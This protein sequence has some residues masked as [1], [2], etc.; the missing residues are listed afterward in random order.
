MES[1]AEGMEI[2][3]EDKEQISSPSTLPLN[4][5][6]FLGIFSFALLIR[7]IY[8][9][10]IKGDPTFNVPLLDELYHHYWAREIAFGDW[11]GR[12]PFFRAP[13][14]PYFLAILYKIFDVNP[15]SAKF[16]QIFLGSLN[17]VLTYLVGKRA[18]G[19]KVGAISGLIASLYGPLIFF[20]AQLLIPVLAVSL[21]LL[22]LLFLQSAFRSTHVHSKNPWISWLAS[23]VLL[24]LAGIARPNLLLFA[25]FVLLLLF[26]QRSRKKLRENLIPGLIFCGGIL[27]MIAPITLRN[28]W[29]ARDF[30]PIAY[31]GG[32]NFYAGNNPSS[33][34]YNVALPE[35]G[36]VGWEEMEG[37]SRIA[38]EEMGKRL[39]PSEVSNFWYR[40]GFDFIRSNPWRFTQLLG[41]K[42]VLFWSGIEISNNKEIYLQSERS[43]LMRVL[44]FKTGVA[45]PFGIVGPLALTGFLLS[46][47]GKEK[48]RIRNW[49]ISQVVGSVGRSGSAGEGGLLHLYLLSVM[50][51]ILPFF[52]CS[53]FRIP[54][55]PVLII[56]AA[57]TVHWLMLRA[58]KSRASLTLPLIIIFSTGVLLNLNTFHIVYRKP[59]RYWYDVGL[60]SSYKGRSSEAISSFERSLEHDFANYKAH[61]SLGI[62]YWGN[63]PCRIR[64]R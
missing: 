39:K 55:I 48:F 32:I 63:H 44:L 62:L 29:V 26:I 51:S 16:I 18:F 14:Y 58:R 61:T 57:Y 46:L 22:S 37:S 49:S 24:G 20:D 28:Y 47:L 25:P 38:E 42:I 45:F 6:L 21:G 43:P 27:L 34:G 56:F 17:C 2:K 7:I 40:K 52:I 8:L 12:E 50:F 59:A 9:F 36:M 41:K 13:L 64:E 19:V 1:E 4:L 11:M 31:Q 15:F 35:M 53:R 33:D 54:A 60:A 23:G 30:V 3:V 5:S 10:Q